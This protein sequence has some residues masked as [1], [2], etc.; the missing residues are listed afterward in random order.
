[1]PLPETWIDLLSKGIPAGKAPGD[2]PLGIHEKQFPGKMRPPVGTVRF[3]RRCPDQAGYR[4]PGQAPVID[5]GSRHLG[6]R[7]KVSQLRRQPREPLGQLKACHVKPG[8]RERVIHQQ[9]LA[10]LVVVL[11]DGPRPRGGT[12]MLAVSLGHLV[13]CPAQEPA[14]PLRDVSLDIMWRFQTS[15]QHRGRPGTPAA[16]HQ[17][18]TFGP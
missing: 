9:N 15:P 2:S 18:V 12:S 3:H 13:P 10:E 14:M 11:K 5:M 1:M 16:S 6:R 8:L 17:N 4:S 7:R